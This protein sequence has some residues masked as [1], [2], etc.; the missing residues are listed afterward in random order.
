MKPT[1]LLI[2]D[3]IDFTNDFI[4][5][6]EGD[7]V[8]LSA[9]N[10]S[11]GFNLFNN[12]SPDIV[13][14]DLI[15]NDGTNGME[16]LKKIIQ[17]DEQ[18]PVIMITDYAS[19]QTA[20]EAIKLGALD[21]ISKTPNLEKL[22][23]LIKRS[24]KQRL[25]YLHTRSLEETVNNPFQT[26]IGKSEVV[27]KMKEQIQLYSQND[28]TVLIT[29]DSGV[30][31]ELVARQIHLKSIRKNKPFVAINCS[32]IPK[33]LLESEL[34]G[35]EKGAFTGAINKKLGK[36]EIA[37]E[38]TIFLDE[39]SEFELQAQV[40]LLRVLQEKEFNRVGGLTTIKT[41]TRIIA[42]SNKNL[43]EEILLN[44]FREDLFYRLAVLPI[45]VARLADRIEDIELLANY[46]L[47]LAEK[48][49][50]KKYMFL[51]EAAVRKLKMHSWPGNIR[52]LRNCI[53]QSALLC[54]TN[55]IEENDIQLP[56]TTEKGVS[57]IPETWED[58]NTM[59]KAAVEEASRRV[60]R[61][62]L[63]NLLL[64]FNGNITKAAEHIGIARTSLHKMIKKSNQAYPLIR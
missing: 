24:L 36:F 29:G 25:Q 20:V 28:Q 27:T 37:S 30:G 31:K 3:D 8:C 6:M 33:E 18:I 40:K 22:K 50:N 56:I 9:R 51:S 13:L 12:N 15:L 60:E 48:E 46:F 62:F 26:I 11:D 53:V 64:K 17:S 35:H 45:H 32:A 38:G 19:T 4:L 63:D 41:N 39:I 54:K 55:T 59:R 34:F 58:L 7:F 10:S 23:V 44:N 47:R 52:E 43:K 14:L 1:L 16:L 49:F 21:Y 2:D 42:A 5:L 57:Q 61:I